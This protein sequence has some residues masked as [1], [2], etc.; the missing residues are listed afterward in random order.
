MTQQPE[1]HGIKG[2]CIGQVV[3]DD[4]YGEGIVEGVKP[5]PSQPWHPPGFE[6]GEVLVRF[7]DG[8]LRSVASSCLQVKEV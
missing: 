2:L 8:D 7:G 3:I 5:T 4:D 1:Q 6:S